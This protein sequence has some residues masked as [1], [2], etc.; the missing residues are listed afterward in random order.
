VTFTGGGRS[1]VLCALFQA[2]K[3]TRVEPLMTHK[4][5]S[6]TAEVCKLGWPFTLGKCWSFLVPVGYHSGMYF[7]IEYIVEVLI[8]SHH[9][10]ITQYKNHNIIFYDTQCYIH[11]YTII[12]Y[13]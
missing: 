8:Y 2:Q 12:K 5:A 9:M 10:D 6:W 1:Q 13:Q 3:G 11:I 7:N 4:L